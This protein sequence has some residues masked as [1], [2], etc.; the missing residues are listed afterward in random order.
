[1]GTLSIVATPIGN[2]EDI[3]F[4]AIEILKKVDLIASEDTR[5]TNFLLQQYDI[6]SKTTTDYTGS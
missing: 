2:L 6:R 5:I 1:M 3:S 4:R